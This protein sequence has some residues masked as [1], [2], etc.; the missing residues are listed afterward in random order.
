MRNWVESARPFSLTAA[1]IPILVGTSLAVSRHHPFQPLNFGIVL[2]GGILLQ[3]ATNMVN[4]GYDFLRGV[5]HDETPRAS[6]TVI[7]G[8]L[9]PSQ[10]IRG[11]LTV[12]G[13]TL[14]LG[15]IMAF[16]VGPLI[17]VPVTVGVLAGWGYTAPP[18]E[19]KYRALGIP[20]V[21]LTMG[22][23][24]TWAAFLGNGGHAFWVPCVVALPVAF[25]V[26]AILHAN[27]LRDIE[28]DRKA[29]VRT[30][31]GLMGY[32]GA[33]SLYDVLLF[34]PYAVV[35]VC[36]ALGWISPFALL[37]FLT[38]PF[39]VQNYRLARKPGRERLATLDQGTA[40]LH[41]LFGLLLAV[42][43]VIM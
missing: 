34:L 42:G 12:F 32:P 18:F 11:G 39:M 15:I 21:F 8:R 6:R 22:P 31:T 3:V 2:V 33:R 28:D 17:L 7:E 29:R 36:V 35:I 4:D 41:L 26:A 20:V 5:D 14:I 24:M 43:L 30:M 23:L 37:A 38:L 27:D 25:L 40:K 1:L 10:A 9:T 13:V 19:Y 16:R